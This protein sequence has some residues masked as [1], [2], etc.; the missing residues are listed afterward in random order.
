[1]NYEQKEVE[2]ELEGIE[3]A[4]AKRDRLLPASIVIAA[5]ILAGTWVYTAGL[6]SRQDQTAVPPR[7]ESNIAA[8][9]SGENAA[10]ESGIVL[11]AKWGNLGK[12]MVAVGVIDGTQFK[13]LYAQRGGMSVDMKAL[14]DADDNGQLKITAQNAGTLLNLLWALGLG[15]K[16]PILEKGP[17]MDPQY[18]SAGNFASTGGWT[19]AKGSPMSH[20]GMHQFVTLTAEQ[21]LLVE[22]VA[23]NIYRPCC[24]NPVY[25]PDCNHGMAMLGLLELMASQGVSEAE[26]YKAALA[27]NSYW[28]PDQYATIAR[29][30]ESKG[31]SPKSVDPKEVLGATYSSG[32]GFARIQALAPAAPSTQQSQ[33]SCGVDAGPAAAPQQQQNSCGV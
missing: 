12:Q 20:Y 19:I 8:E 17:M 28:F 29:Y 31:I 4:P 10:S 1:M 30:F 11:P 26:M 15:N 2:P 27:A 32:Q 24:G 5:V 16:N 22:K 13:A 33:G 18:G 21:Q 23:K 9:P 7:S 25:F 6:K 3:A 14:L